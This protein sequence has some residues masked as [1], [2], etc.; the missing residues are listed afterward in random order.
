MPYFNQL[1]DA[2]Q[3]NEYMTVMSILAQTRILP[4]ARFDINRYQDDYTPLQQAAIFCSDPRIVTALLE[5]GADPSL[6]SHPQPN[7]PYPRLSALDLCLKRGNFPN[8]A[9]AVAILEH[10]IKTHNDSVDLE[11]LGKGLTLTDHAR[12]LNF[13][14]ALQVLEQAKK[15]RLARKEMQERIGTLTKKLIDAITKKDAEAVRQSLREAQNISTF[16]I[17]L[18]TP[19]GKTLLDHALDAEHPE[20]CRLLIQAGANVNEPSNGRTPIKKL[21]NIIHT[22]YGTFTGASYSLVSPYKELLSLV[23]D[24]PDP[25]GSPLRGADLKEIYYVNTSTVPNQPMSILAWIATN[26]RFQDLSIQREDIRSNFIKVRDLILNAHRF[27]DRRV[28]DIYGYQF[29]LEGLTQGITT[30]ELLSS[31]NEFLDKKDVREEL[32]ALMNL[33]HNT[34]GIDYYQQAIQSK[35]VD[36]ATQTAIDL[37]ATVEPLDMRIIQ[38]NQQH[39]QITAIPVLTTIKERGDHAQSYLICGDHCIRINCGGTVDPRGP[40]G[41]TV[42]KIGD[43]K[44]FM[45][46]VPTLLK[47]HQEPVKDEYLLG[48]FVKKGNLQEVYRVKVPSQIVGNCTWKSTEALNLAIIFMNIFKIQQKSH[49]KEP[50]FCFHWAEI[51]AKKWQDLFI[52]HDRERGLKQC[53]EFQKNIPKYLLAGMVQKE[54]DLRSKETQKDKTWLKSFKQARASAWRKTPRSPS[55]SAG[56]AEAEN[57]GIERKTHYE[58]LT[59]SKDNL[60]AIARDKLNLDQAGLKALFEAINAEEYEVNKKDHPAYITALMQFNAVTIDPVDADS[61]EFRIQFED[62]AMRSEFTRRFQNSAGPKA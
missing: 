61:N 32:N 60:F 44:T 54:S 19:D 62:S 57:V 13:Q 4:S 12:A 11:S 24:G 16:N 1:C 41:I 51:V 29:S 56:S 34:D 5:Y 59:V 28:M 33:A 21:L 22:K 50:S 10:I 47:S 38:D 30:L 43:M 40:Q 6:L 49:P 45:E 25:H 53:L 26:F 39:D 48:Q 37:R 23:I 2:I 46:E 58:T 27:E 9:N 15:I 55:G 52:T 18:K 14:E 3:K 8:Q 17:N 7:T 35:T 36:L 20:I 42:Y 31:Y